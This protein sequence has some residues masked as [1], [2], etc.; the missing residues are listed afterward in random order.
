MAFTEL[1]FVHTLPRVT[2]AAVVLTEVTGVVAAAAVADACPFVVAVAC[3]A[4]V[5]A[6]DA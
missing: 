4:A 5:G 3:V 2:S 6:G 1:N